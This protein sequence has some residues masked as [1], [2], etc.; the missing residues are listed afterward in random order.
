MSIDLSADYTQ[1]PRF[2]EVVWDGKDDN[3]IE[4]GAGVYFYKLSSSDEHIG[5]VVKLR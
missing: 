3:G 5:K 2:Y 1:L 4:M